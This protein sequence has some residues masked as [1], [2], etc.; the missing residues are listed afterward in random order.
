MIQDG[1][2][3]QFTNGNEEGV[4]FVHRAILKNLDLST[5]YYY[6]VKSGRSYSPIFF[7]ETRNETVTSGPNI[8]VLGDMGRKGGAVSLDYI[9][10]ESETGEYDF[11]FHNGDFAY[12]LDSDGGQNG[13]EF[14][15]RI[16]ACAGYTPYMTSPGNHEAGDDFSNYIN[17]FTMPI[18]D[19]SEPLEMWYSFDYQNIHFISYSTEVYFSQQEYIQTQYEWLENDLIQANKNRVIIIKQMIYYLSL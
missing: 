1:Y 12:D 2:C 10:K 14:M 6:R 18:D 7:F 17:R 11:I 9:I 4:Q 19:P 5:V 8:I 16:E 15:R 13:D 3:N